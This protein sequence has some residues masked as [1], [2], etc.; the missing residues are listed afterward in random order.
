MAGGGTLT[1]KT[2]MSRLKNRLDQIVRS[3]RIDFID[4]GSG[5]PKDKLKDIFEVYY[6]MKKTG[7]GLGL[8]IARQIVEGHFGAIEVESEAGKGACLTINLPIEPV[9]EILDTDK[10]LTMEH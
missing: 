2:R 5:I 7:T 9:H 6:T 10:Q 1:I 4:D 3:L 8:A